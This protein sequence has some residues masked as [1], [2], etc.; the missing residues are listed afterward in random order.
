MPLTNGDWSG[1]WIKGS[2][3]GLV[4]ILFL[5]FFTLTGSQHSPSWHNSLQ[6]VSQNR[7]TADGKILKE[8]GNDLHWASNPFWQGVKILQFT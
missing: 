4:I 3:T 6:T 7:V 5:D 2:S 8:G 1:L